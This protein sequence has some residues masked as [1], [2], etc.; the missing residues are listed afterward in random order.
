VSGWWLGHSIRVAYAG[1][2]PGQPSPLRRFMRIVYLR[3]FEQ[4]TQQ[5]IAD[6]IGVTQMQV[7]RLLARILRDLRGEITTA[8]PETATRAS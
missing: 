1:H 5:E 6:E 2:A 8:G 7:S 4:R 3:F